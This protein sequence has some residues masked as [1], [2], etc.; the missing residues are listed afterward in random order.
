VSNDQTGNVMY[1]LHLSPEQLEIRDTV[2]DFGAQ[3]IK[4]IVLD[5]QRLDACD[6]HLPM[7]L[8]HQASLMGLRT[9]ALSEAAGGA[10]ADHL[11]CCL[12]TE[13]LAA[14]DADF[15]AT[16]AETSWL[17]HVLFDRV[18]TD[19]QRER[20]L[21]KFLK[22]GG[23]HLAV[24]S[25]EGSARLGIHYHRSPSDTPAPKITATKVGGDWIV[26]GTVDCVINAPIAGLLAVFVTIQ[27]RAAA[28]ALLVP[29][30]ARRESRCTLTR[31]RGCTASPA[32]SYLRTAA[33]R[34][35]ISSATTPLHC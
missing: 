10:G 32:P 14:C 16:F 29:G 7:E 1:N 4:P 34:A 26:N 12:V 20:F 17:G 31:T 35:T 27:G 6:R 8:L 5:S 22:D 11:T 21:P 15:A 33:C 18:V 13:E 28:A 23:F 30:G 19:D 9:L 24:A 25:N 3:K 2:R